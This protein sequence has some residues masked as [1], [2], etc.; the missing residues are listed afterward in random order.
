MRGGK[1]RFMSTV[2]DYLSASRAQ[3]LERRALGQGRSL[4]IW[5]NRRDRI[6]YD[7]PQDHTVSLYL[8][9]GHG[10]RRLDR[11]GAKGYPGALCVMPEGERSEWE[12]NADFRFAHLYLPDEELRYFYARTH[13]RSPGRLCVAGRT[14]D[15]DPGLIAFMRALIGADD[16]L[17]R[18]QALTGV[19]GVLVASGPDGA[20]RGGLT[21][22]V[23]RR[24][25]AALRDQMEHPPGLSDLARLAGLSPWHF[26]RMFRVT[27]GVTPHGWLERARTAR[28]QEM[29]AQGKPLAEIAAACGYSSQSHLTRAFSR[30]TGL[31]PARYRAAISP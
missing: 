9:G 24:V 2:F 16:P 30:A 28:A 7:E 3:C 25:C 18:E 27:H 12:I 13:D 29:I 6:D 5:R 15:R 21:P 11:G 1:R 14:F 19:M 17:A 23:S 8:S 4:V 31:T 22:A 26:Q 20:Q 10:S